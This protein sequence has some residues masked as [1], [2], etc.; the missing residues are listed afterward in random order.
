MKVVHI[1]YQN[2]S[3]KVEDLSMILGYFDGVHL[4]H[5]YLIK[6]ARKYAKYPLA[7]LTFDKPVSSLIANNKNSDLLTSLDDRFK[8]IS[9]LGVDYYYVFHIDKEFLNLSSQDFIELLKE[10]NVREVFAGSDFRFGKNRAGGINELKDYFEVRVSDLLKENE[11]KISTQEI[12]DLVELGNIKE[13]NKLLGYNYQ[14]SGTL[15]SGKG[16]G[17]KIGFPTLN[18]KMSANYVLPRFG[19][20]KTITYLDGLPHLSITN[21]G[22]NP[23]VDMGNVPTI[24]VHLKEYKD[25]EYSNIIVEFIEFVRPE[26]KFESLD[27]LKK[28]IEKDTKKVFEN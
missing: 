18:V 17:H 9:K 1:Y 2:I 6:E 21:V 8:M 27:E 12:K 28:Q 5:Q 3:A 23:T 22:L 15:I 20:Y 16:I 19:V 7:I 4:G 11:E 13:A 24:E 25:K 26:I 10:L 14:I